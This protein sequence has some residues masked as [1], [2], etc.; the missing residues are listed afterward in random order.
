MIASATTAT[1]TLA[2]DLRLATTWM[3]EV[4]ADL[5]ASP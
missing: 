1:R 5:V 3:R 2:E 4:R